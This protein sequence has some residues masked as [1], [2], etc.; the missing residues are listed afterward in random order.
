MFMVLGPFEGL[1]EAIPRLARRLGGRLSEPHGVLTY[2]V[3]GWGQHRIAAPFSIAHDCG[4]INKERDMTVSTIR[5]GI[6]TLGLVMI[7]MAPPDAFTFGD[8]AG[9]S[10]DAGDGR[11]ATAPWYRNTFAKLRA[12]GTHPVEQATPVPSKGRAGRAQPVSQPA[13]PEV[14]VPGT[15]QNLRRAGGP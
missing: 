5:S 3:P 8:L 12:A 11:A 2:R 14:Q 13:P 10:G 9:L 6:G 4:S 15:V 1:T 7:L